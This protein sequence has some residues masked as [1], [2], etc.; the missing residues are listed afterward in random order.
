MTK[1]LA[2]FVFLTCSSS[3]W[4]QLV[5]FKGAPQTAA[6][7][8]Y[9]PKFAVTL[10]VGQPNYIAGADVLGSDQP[11]NVLH[12]DLQRFS[13]GTGLCFRWYQD[14]TF[15]LH[16]RMM[17]S[18][19]RYTLYD[20]VIPP[21]DV[22]G[23]GSGGWTTTR[24]YTNV[25]YNAYR[26]NN[27]LF[28]VGGGHEGRYG[29]FIVRAGGEIDFISYSDVFVQTDARAYVVV[30][31]DSTNGG[32]YSS[33]QV[34]MSTDRTTSPG[35]WAIGI[36]GHAALEY[37]LNPH[38]GIGATIYLGGFYCGVKSKN[39]KQ[40]V[41]NS[42]SFTDTQGSNSHYSSDV[43]NELPY[44]VRQFDFSPLNAQINFAYY[45]GEL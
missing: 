25:R 35:L 37:K 33:S 34:Q 17:Y 4:A 2:L 22:Y 5:V 21:P 13:M 20:S 45:F 18:T 43:V 24:E 7:S 36:T 1:L 32:Q 15:F 14:E 40:E 31:S 27:L 12:G 3:A 41:H 42:N 26:M 30:H 44:S 19:R 10:L 9:N 23:S 29:N 16:A 38:F 11:F 39:W 8:A 28:G 6:D